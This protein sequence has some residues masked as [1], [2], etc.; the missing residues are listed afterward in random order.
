MSTPNTQPSARMDYRGATALV[1]GASSGIG[2]VFAERLAAAGAGLVLVARR[3]D[4]LEHLAEG[5]RAR[6]RVTVEVIPA[7][8]DDPGAAAQV[9]HALDERGVLID[10]LINNAGFGLHGDLAEAD[11]DRTLGMIRVNCLAVVDLTAR[12]LPGMRS[13]RR[14]AVVNVA[15]TAAFQPLPH[16][17]VY[18]A[19]KAFVL[20]FSEA[21]SVEVKGDGVRVLAL[22]PGATATEFFS[23]AGESAQVGAQQS[24]DEVVDVALRGLGRGRPSVIPGVRNALLALTPR[25]LPR[26]VVLAASERAMR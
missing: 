5:L 11:L 22:C 14:G 15:S 4:V 2:A 17:A 21:L 6:H 26:R 12:L 24:A 7:D 10:V 13:R 18:G 23:V 9:C 16:M 3:K 8:L 1:T 20:S 19:S 25:L